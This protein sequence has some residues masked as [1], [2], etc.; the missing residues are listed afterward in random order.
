MTR[1]GVNINFRQ[2][3]KQFRA[4]AQTRTF[5]KIK[6]NIPYNMYKFSR[7]LFAK[8]MGKSKDMIKFKFG[9]VDEKKR[10]N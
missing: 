1:K 3:A 9:K 10:I 8:Q 4:L 2:T 5:S 7:S 6:R